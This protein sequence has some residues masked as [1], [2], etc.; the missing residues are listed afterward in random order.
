M[1]IP[2]FLLWRT[3]NEGEFAADM[4]I[5]GARGFPT[6]GP[7]GDTSEQAGVLKEASRH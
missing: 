7:L 4:K 1:V 5:A 2:V 6:S 3:R